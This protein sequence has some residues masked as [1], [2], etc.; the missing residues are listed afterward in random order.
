MGKG[1][2]RSRYSDKPTLEQ[3]LVDHALRIVA[4]DT[5]DDMADEILHLP[6][7]WELD[8]WGLS[9]AAEERRTLLQRVH[10]SKTPEEGREAV[11]AFAEAVEISG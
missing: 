8:G 7:P 9:Q 1:K 2:P 5:L 10:E 6:D 4:K 3:R 11:M